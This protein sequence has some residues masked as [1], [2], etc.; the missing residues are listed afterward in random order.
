MG[1]LVENRLADTHLLTS[2]QKSPLMVPGRELAGLVSPS[3]T[4][5]VFTTPLP[6]H[7][8]TTEGRG[9]SPAAL[10]EEL[11]LISFPLRATNRQT[12]SA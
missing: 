5:P 7:T 8:W 9:L 12:A 2:M 11:K 6:S 3:I 10:P 4:R 1:R